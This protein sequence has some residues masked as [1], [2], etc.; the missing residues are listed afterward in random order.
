MD[1]RLEIATR[2]IA[3][4]IASYPEDV[5]FPGSIHHKKICCAAL[6][7]ADALIAEHNKT[8]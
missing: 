6:E 1:M 7:L 2:F 5:D 4:Y 3:G 8:K